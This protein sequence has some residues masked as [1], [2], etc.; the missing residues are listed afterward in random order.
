MLG[1]CAFMAIYGS[2]FAI[3]SWDNPSPVL[4]LP[5][6]VLYGPVALCFALMAVR[7]LQVLWGRSWE[8]DGARETHAG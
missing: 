6:T 1:F 5:M 7:Y 8:I 3:S 2:I 4:R